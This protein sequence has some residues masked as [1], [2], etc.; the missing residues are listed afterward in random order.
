MD[1]FLP[2]FQRRGSEYYLS[3]NLQK[4]SLETLIEINKVFILFPIQHGIVIPGAWTSQAN[5]TNQIK[6]LKANR[7]NQ[8]E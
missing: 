8:I 1:I 2:K 7:T 6:Q 3:D 5:R 4:N